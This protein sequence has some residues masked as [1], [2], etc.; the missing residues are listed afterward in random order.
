MR[1]PIIPLL[2]LASL[3]AGTWT[4]AQPLAAEPRAETLEVKPGAPE[5]HVVEK[6]D[7]LWGIAGKY[8][9]K[10]WRW[11]EI[12]RLNRE[13]IKNPHRIYPG[14]VIVLDR[15]G[16]GPHLKLLRNQKASATEVLSPR[17]RTEPLPET[18]AVPVISPADIGPF[19]SQPL[20]IEEGGLKSAPEIVASEENRVI[21]GAGNRA[22]AAGLEEARPLWQ[23]F[24][25]GKALIDPDTREVLGYEAVY[26][27]DA[28][29]VRPGEPATLEIVRSTQ[30]ITRGD[31]LV[32]PPATE[33]ANILPHAPDKPV[34]GRI[35]SAYG[36]VAETGRGA[37]VALN[38][39]SRD[40]LE[41]GH[42]LAIRRTGEVVKASLEESPKPLRS[43]HQDECLRPEAK[44]RFD[45]FYDRSKAW[46]PCPEDSAKKTLTLPEERYGLALVFRT[47]DRVS[48]ALVLQSSLA[49]RVGDVISNP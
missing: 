28:R 32:P 4:M 25:P 45:E 3:A 2:L 21:I 44:V 19:L 16:A 17:V 23:I 30:E 13:Q 42:V 37:I 29:V 8:L 11:P 26:L 18:S 1:K 48:Y 14:D 9:D 40:G 35:L 20:V 27:G 41:P 10:P 15:D 34:R 43:W 24:R 49:V 46:G 36:G 47:F 39:G 6:G 5:R 38:R 31:R 33:L 7:T 12:W 22:Y